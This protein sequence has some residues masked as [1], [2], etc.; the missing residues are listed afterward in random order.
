MLEKFYS[1]PDIYNVTTKSLMSSTKGGQRYHL[2]DQHSLKCFPN[3]KNHSKIQA[4]GKRYKT[5]L[6]SH[7]QV[8][9]WN[10][11]SELSRNMKINLTWTWE[12]TSKVTNSLQGF[13]KTGKKTY[14][15]LC[16][17]KCFTKFKKKKKRRKIC[18]KRK[19][20]HMEYHSRN[21]AS[22]VASSTRITSVGSSASHSP[23]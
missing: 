5:P 9:T 15:F 6:P 1:I 18:R 20:L 8:V 13:W 11:V 12:P 4:L 17:S 19:W 22:S 16:F 3:Y 14:I 21:K 7:Y 23:K 2:L 10:L